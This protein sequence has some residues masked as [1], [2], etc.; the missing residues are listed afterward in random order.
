MEENELLKILYAENP[1]WENRKNQTPE[2]KRRDFF[3]LKKAL[4]ER[5]IS[6]IIGP[7]RVGKTVLMDQLIQDLLDR[8]VPPKNILYMQFDDPKFDKEQDSLIAS[9]MDAYSKNILEKSFHDL[10]EKVYVFFD[11]IQKI[12]KWSDTIKASYYDR[13]YKIKFTVSG[14]SSTELTKGS[15]ESLVGRIMLH[16]VMPLKFIDYLRFKSKRD[17]EWLNSISLAVRDGLMA[18]LANKDPNYFWQEL[19]TANTKLAPAQNEIEIL[20]SEYLVKGGYIEL[21]SKEDYPACSKYLR[22]MLQLVIY[23]DIVK[24]FDVRNPSALEDVLLYLATHSSERLSKQNL[25][26]TMKLKIDTLSEYLNYLKDVFIITSSRIYASNR[27]KQLRNPE[28]NYIM[29]TG[30]RNA[31][32]GTYSKLA[33]SNSTDVGLMADTVVH[34]HLRRLSFFLG[35]QNAECFYWKNGTEVDHVLVYA[36]MPFPVEVKYRNKI[37]NEDEKGIKLFL[38]ENEKSHFGIIITKN[39]LEY[40]NNVFLI[41]LWL[42]LLLC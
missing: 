11:E 20:L 39:K 35:S 2:A 1:W 12:K 13:N 31:L 28:K 29:D 25:S 8:G 22:E 34:D 4:D 17:P 27:A 7:R 3:V 5:M 16:Y 10:K 33:L 15:S 38:K 41:P 9:V 19:K 26:Q 40:K 24:V 42:F 37:N 36:R 23:R 6:A 32:N 30:L 14:S 18:S 21:L